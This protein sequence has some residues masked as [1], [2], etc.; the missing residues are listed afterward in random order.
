ML[1]WD[2]I[3]SNKVM[4]YRYFTWHDMYVLMQYIG[5]KDKNG[6]EVYE[7]DIYKYEGEIGIFR[8]IEDFYYDEMLQYFAEEGEIIGNIYEN[9]ELKGGKR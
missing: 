5:L 4:I 7:G 2:E 3:L 8:S 1:L 9:P 6:K